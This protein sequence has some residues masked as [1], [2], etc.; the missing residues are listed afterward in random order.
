MF[1]CY[2]GDRDS[3]QMLL[4]YEAER[5]RPMVKTG[6][7]PLTCLLLGQASDDL[8]DEMGPRLLKSDNPFLMDTFGLN[9]LHYAIQRNHPTLVKSILEKRE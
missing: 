8:I 4:K 5:D 9:V 1:A 7:T 3:I 2:L 6:F